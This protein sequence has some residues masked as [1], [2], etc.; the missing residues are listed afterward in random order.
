MSSKKIILISDFSLQQIVGGGEL[1]DSELVKL[2][3]QRGYGVDH[4]QSSSVT[5]EYLE[6]NKNNFFIVSNF[7]N[8]NFR[9]IQKLIDCN[10]IIYE[11]DHKYLRNRNPAVYKDFKAPNPEILVYFF[12]KNA[13]RVLCQSK[14]HKE[15]VEK[16]LN[17]N[18]IVSLGGNLWSDESLA[19]IREVCKRPKKP[20]V[21][22][23]KSKTPHKNT[24]GAIEYCNKEGI[25]FELVANTDY[26]KF[27]EALG[28]NEK[29]VFLPQTP[30]TLS[31]VV[32]EARMMGQKVL[33][34][35]LVG[36]TSEEWFKLKG[37]ALID[38]M[39][40]KRDE[41]VDLIEKLAQ[42]VR[43][44][45]ARPLVS[46]ICTFHEAEEY[47]ENYL[48]NITSQT[49]F[50]KCELI[51]IDA[52]SPGSEKQ[53]VEKYLS[54]HKN[55][56]YSRLNE[57]EKI[58]PC[59]NM[60]LKSA[61]GNFL[62]FGFVDDVKKSDCIE[63][64]HGH[65]SKSPNI[66]LV[67]GDVVETST[68][69]EKFENN[70]LDGTLYDHCTYEFSKENMVKCLPGP[71][72]LWRRELHD[73]CGF[74]DTDNDYAD[75]WEMWLRAVNSGAVFKKV[76]E[77]V[78]LYYIGGRS[79]QEAL[80]STQESLAQRKEEA[81]L[82]FKYHDLFGNNFHVYKEYFAQFLQGEV[83]NEF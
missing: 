77:I 17:L 68:K 32:V 69:N 37:E 29:F 67:Y 71:M 74:L 23:L 65:I 79:Y 41:I 66:D 83:Y 18:N 36:A 82:F 54:R 26:Y 44:D 11:H 33:T 40:E 38:F 50:D 78:G 62:T 46:I 19:R 25:K 24:A 53:I 5:E 73:R 45:T 59:L 12:Y 55:I 3:G 7:C 15:I 64:L 31:R 14:F 34:N 58:T 28:A 39:I 35:G 80:T 72:P 16:N 61:R 30:E 52:G 47:L 60:A 13:I 48:Q 63:T 51:I 57:R 27:L 10:Y 4:I 49:F 81:Q 43:Q 42:D 9:C 76:H 1:N 2:L 70:L 20:Q 56:I 22:I 8:L 75:D 21:S 6:Q